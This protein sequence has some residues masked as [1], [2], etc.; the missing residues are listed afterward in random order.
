MR[1][2]DFKHLEAAMEAFTACVDE[3]MLL[4]TL[5]TST[6]RLFHREAA[7]I[8]LAAEADQLHLRL[9]EGA[10]ATVTS[11]LQ[12]MRGSASGERTVARRLHKLG[13]LAVLAA[14]LRVHDRMVGMVAAGSQRSQRPGRIDAAI[15]KILV[16]YAMSALER[17]QPPPAVEGEA[18]RRHMTARR[19]LEVQNERMRFLNM[20]ISGITHDLNNTMATISGRVELLLNRLHDQVTLR[21]LGAAHRAINEA[22]HLIRHLRDVMGGRREDGLVLVDINQLVRDSLQIARSTWFQGFRHTHVPVDL[23]ADLNPTPALP[24]T[25]SDLRIALLCLLRHAMDAVRPGGGLMVRTWSEGE[26]EGRT[27]SISIS[28]APGQ[29]PSAEREEGIGSLL[30]QLPTPES[31]R[32]LEFAQTIIRDLD[33]QIAVDRSADGGTTT[34]LTFSVRGAAPGEH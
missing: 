19:D 22:G 31:R 25:P 2:Q 24:S 34:T 9:A 6:Q 14:P 30:R 8:W 15:F 32:A 5:L 4:T 18:A 29:S 3:D 11:S 33:G 26:G 12:R 28:D 16:R 23:G 1:L 13:Y 21:H 10:P 7:F 17:L 27:V 20:A